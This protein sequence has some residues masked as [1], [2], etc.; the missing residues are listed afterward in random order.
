MQANTG[1][2]SSDNPPSQLKLLCRRIGDLANVVLF[3]V[4]GLS[5]ENEHPLIKESVVS[6]PE[7]FLA[8]GLVIEL[9]VCASHFAI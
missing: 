6:R 1:T 8:A 3:E 4:Q 7:D 9:P 2:E 5:V